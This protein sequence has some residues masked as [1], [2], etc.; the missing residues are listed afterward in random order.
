MLTYLVALPPLLFDLERDPEQFRNLA[1]DPAHQAIVREYAQRALSWRMR[2][3][4]KALTH[5][6]ASPTGLR[7]R[8]TKRS[9]S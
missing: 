9:S 7:S 3:A 8:A 1:A 5:F 4:D 2:H 6:Q